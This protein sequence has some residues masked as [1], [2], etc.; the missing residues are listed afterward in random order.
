M[1]KHTP[2]GSSGLTAAV[3]AKR[4]AKD[5]PNALPSGQRRGPGGDDTPLV[6]SG[7]LVVAG[8]GAGHGHRGA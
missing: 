1:D 5:G 7:M 2:T 8:Q 6:Y 4:L 3:A